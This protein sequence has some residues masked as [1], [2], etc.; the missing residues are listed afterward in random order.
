MSTGDGGTHLGA[1]GEFVVCEVD[2][3]KGAL[4]NQTAQSVAADVPQVLGREFSV[5]TG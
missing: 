4:P 1:I 2:F 3:A 5:E